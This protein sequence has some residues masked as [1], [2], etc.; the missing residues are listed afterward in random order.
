MGHRACLRPGREGQEKNDE[1]AL[2]YYQK[3]AD[4]GE[5]AAQYSFGRPHE[6]GELGTDNSNLSLG[7]D[8]ERLCAKAMEY[9]RKATGTRNIFSAFIMISAV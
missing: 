7:L 6:N 2:E 8:M 3:P 9:Y 1:K 5:M 4:G